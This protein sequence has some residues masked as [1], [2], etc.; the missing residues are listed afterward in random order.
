MIISRQ[1]GFITAKNHPKSGA[2]FLIRFP[3]VTNQSP[4]SHRGVI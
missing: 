1:G 4:E 2:F 3:K